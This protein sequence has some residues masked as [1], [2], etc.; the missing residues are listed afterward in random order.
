[1][2][3]PVHA[4]DEPVGRASIPETGGIMK[5]FVLAALGTVAGL[6]LGAAVGILAG[7]AW[8]NIVSINDFEGQSAMLVFFTFAPAGSVLGG[9]AGAIWAGFTASKS[10]IRR[11]GDT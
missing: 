7:I 4:R 8:V 11:E 10:R 2:N 1:M 5:T 3:L 6:V 9:L